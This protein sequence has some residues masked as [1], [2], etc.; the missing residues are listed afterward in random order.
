MSERQFPLTERCAACT[1]LPVSWLPRMER[2]V[3]ASIGS[4]MDDR[5][6]TFAAAMVWVPWFGY[7]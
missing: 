1:H 2:L 7:A 5:I 4:V 6:A 3:A